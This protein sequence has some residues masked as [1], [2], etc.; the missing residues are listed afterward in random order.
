[1]VYFK[2]IVSDKVEIEKHF[3]VRINFLENINVIVYL[4]VLDIVVLIISLQI[5]K[6]YIDFQKVVETV[7]QTVKTIF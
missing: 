7:I 2:D 5:L 6:N 4:F 1:M 3:K